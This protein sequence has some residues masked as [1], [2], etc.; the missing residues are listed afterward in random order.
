MTPFSTLS[1]QFGQILIYDFGFR[2]R[3]AIHVPA[4]EPSEPGNLRGDAA[5]EEKELLA[6]MPLRPGNPGTQE[7]RNLGTCD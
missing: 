6:A 7:P 1:S 3:S 4:R 5:A 2:C